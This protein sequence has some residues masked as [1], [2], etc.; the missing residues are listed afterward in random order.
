[1][2]TK[3]NVITLSILATLMI[4]GC[5]RGM[6]SRYVSPLT[7]NKSVESDSPDVNPRSGLPNYDMAGTESA[8]PVAVESNKHSDVG[9]GTETPPAEKPPEPVK[10]VKSNPSTTQPTDTKPVVVKPQ[11]AKP[12]VVKPPEKKLITPVIALFDFFPLLWEKTVIAAK[13][14]TQIIYSVI[15]KEESYLLGQNVADDVEIFCPTY[16]KLNEEQRL[17]FWGQFF[18]ALAYHESGWSPVSRMVEANFKSMDSVTKQ[19]VV[20]EGLLQLS[21]QDEPSYHLECDFDW[22][23]DKN[24]TAKDPKKTILNPY[25]NLRCGIKI[26]SVQLKKYRSI[27]MSSNVYWAVLKTNG[28]YSKIS[29]ISRLSRSLKICQN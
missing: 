11:D 19:P 27:T 5:S 1:M 16:R 28:L 29:Q 26:M 15:K 24:L 20:S 21:Y 6:K 10:S 4:T 17:N 14:W 25:N 8:T 18:A 7:Q 13:G 12:V 3:L 23:K 9:A 22:N 2:K